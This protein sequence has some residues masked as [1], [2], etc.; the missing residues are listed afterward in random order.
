MCFL[1]HTTRAHDSNVASRSWPCAARVATT[2]VQRVRE[3]QTGWQCYSYSYWPVRT[4]VPWEQRTGRRF[5]FTFTGNLGN[6]L[7]KALPRADSARQ[8]Y[9]QT[10]IAMWMRARVYLHSSQVAVA[11][12][13]R[14]V[15]QLCMCT[16]ACVRLLRAVRVCMS[17]AAVRG[18]F[19]LHSVT[20]SAYE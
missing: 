8:S 14:A 2:A 10:A 13:R 18:C 20:R 1:W 16:C 11:E 5:L 12:Q 15:D 3:Q 7:G 9:V 6:R 4:C 19:S 17:A